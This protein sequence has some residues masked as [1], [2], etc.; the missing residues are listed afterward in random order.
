MD[1]QATASQVCAMWDAADII[2][3]KVEAMHIL[4]A[5][6]GKGNLTTGY[7]QNYPSTLTLHIQPHTQGVGKGQR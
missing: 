2:A 4:R 7:C 1:L 5:I 6:T 3:N